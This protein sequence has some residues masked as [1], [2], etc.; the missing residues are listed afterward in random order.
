M[1]AGKLSSRAS[2][3]VDVNKCTGC[4]A[5]AMAC[6]IANDL[7]VDRSW[8]TVNTFN[9]LHVPGIELLHLS[10][11]CNHCTDA[12]CMA[13]CPADAY[14]RDDLTDAVLINADA[15]VGCQYCAWVCP[16]DAPKFD[17]DAGVMTK[18]TFCV[19]RQHQGLAP[20]CTDACPT[21]A[22]DWDKLIPEELT[23][24]VP[25][26]ADAECLPAIQVVGLDE[27]RLTPEMTHP[28]AMPPWERV[29]EWITPKITLRHEW[30]LAFFTL[31]L[32]FLTGW[33]G[34]GQADRY[35]F[36]VLGF[37]GM[38]LSASH[39]G[40]AGR[41]L[42]AAFNLKSS[43]L[44]REIFLVGGFL[45]LA[46][47]VLW[48]PPTLTDSLVPVQVATLFLGFAMLLTV[49]TVYHPAVVRG[50]GSL[51]S[52]QTMWTALLIGWAFTGST[53]II[54][55]AL[56]K[57]VF[58]ISRARNRRALDLPCSPR[59]RITRLV[60]LLVGTGWAA[61]GFGPWPA[62]ALLMVGE[63]IDRAEFY[64]E[65]EI[66]GPKSLMED[67]LGARVGALDG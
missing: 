42:R 34:S 14:Y 53:L 25:G 45:V 39:L 12:P 24:V 56:I 28:G 16:Y 58:Y 66:P 33:F 21:G 46:T 9:E 52:A 1:S 38:G 50:N 23:Q 49:D 63:A 43:W 2:F 18:C 7:P 54:M 13:Q 59:R 8:R 62:V 6:T 55:A 11:A 20:A 67:E 61:A 29:R 19:D 31:L 51:H 15:C 10:L 30:T 5:C 47:G 35:T 60:T 44:S 22:L 48:W 57:L 36:P 26:F 41:G 64:D 4:H 17:P 40:R 65:L 3:I 27:K 32:A 37:M